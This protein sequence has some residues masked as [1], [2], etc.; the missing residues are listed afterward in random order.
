MDKKER[1]RTNLLRVSLSKGCGWRRGLDKKERE[2]DKSTA[3]I[4]I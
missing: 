3:G 1:R 4:S 2:K